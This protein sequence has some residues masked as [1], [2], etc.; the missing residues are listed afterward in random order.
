MNVVL[1]SWYCLGLNNSS[2]FDL[3]V[4]VGLVMLRVMVL[5][6]A[7]VMSRVMVML[8]AMVMNRVRIRVMVMCILK[9]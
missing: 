2:T 9:Y 4:K 7:M 3:G 5:F 6:M 8:M 1:L